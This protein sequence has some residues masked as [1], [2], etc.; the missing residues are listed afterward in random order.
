MFVLQSYLQKRIV[1]F[2]GM[3]YFMSDHTPSEP[4]KAGI[5]HITKLIIIFR[6]L[7]GK[8]FSKD[9]RWSKINSYIFLCTACFQIPAVSMIT[10]MLACGCLITRV[11]ITINI[12]IEADS[13]ISQVGRPIGWFI[14]QGI[15]YLNWKIWIL[16]ALDLRLTIFEDSTTL[17]D[18]L[19]GMWS[20]I[21]ERI[22]NY[23]T[24]IGVIQL[25][26]DANMWLVCIWI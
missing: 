14:Y 16:H 26:C 12:N 1:S 17:D 11:H 7:F 6:Y 9:K 20:S 24:G 13:L 2:R 5:K 4:T 15:S 21:A 3:L 25:N 8:S 19:I 10:P 22:I 23:R 18:L